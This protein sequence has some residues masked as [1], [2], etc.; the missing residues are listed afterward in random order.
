MGTLVTKKLA[1]FLDPNRLNR[2]KSAEVQCRER[3]LLLHLLM[4]IFLDTYSV[5]LCNLPFYT[6]N[7]NDYIEIGRGTMP[8]ENSIITSLMRIFLDTCSVSFL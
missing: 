5:P 3:T 8:R 6:K 4:R 1:G 2:N 7:R